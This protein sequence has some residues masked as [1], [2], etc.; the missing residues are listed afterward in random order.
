MFADSLQL[1]YPLL[2]DHPNLEV[3]R[4]YG[5]LASNGQYPRRSFFLIDPQG[6][7][8]GRWRGKG[9]EVFSDEPL[10]QAVEEM[11]GEPVVD[12]EEKKP[13]GM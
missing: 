10:L 9:S 4:N 6:I 3:I 2:S 5:V 12:T 11:A 13:A 1:P 8:R 7:I